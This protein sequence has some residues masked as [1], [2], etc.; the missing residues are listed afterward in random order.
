MDREF[1]L[2]QENIHVQ[3]HALCEK[4]QNKKEE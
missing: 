3:M 4:D 1:K 2:K